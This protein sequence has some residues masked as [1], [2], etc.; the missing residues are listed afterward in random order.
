[1]IANE[2]IDSRKRSKI[3]R[4]IFKVDFEK[5]YDRVDWSFVDYMLRKFGFGDTWRG[6][7][8]ECILT[9]SFFVLVNGSPSRLFKVSRGIWQG[10]SLSPLLFTIVVEALRIW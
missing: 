8:R 4:V 3:V 9:T 1:M 2:L 6:W 10:D 7:M 5:A